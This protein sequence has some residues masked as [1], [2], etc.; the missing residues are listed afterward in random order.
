MEGHQRDTHYWRAGMKTGA[1]LALVVVF[2]IV[3]ILLL[4][5]VLRVG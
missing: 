4:L 1:V 5:G 2:G 3:A